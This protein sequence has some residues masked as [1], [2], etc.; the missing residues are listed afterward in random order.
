VNAFLICVFFFTRSDGPWFL[1]PL[2]GWGIGIY[3]HLIGTFWP[4]K[5][6]Q[7]EAFQK[8]KQKR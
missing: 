3:F 2:F 7:K 8:W 5:A 4:D 1:G 6:S